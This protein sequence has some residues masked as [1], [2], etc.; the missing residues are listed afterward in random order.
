MS[1]TAA[2]RQVTASWHGSCRR[3]YPLPVPA[4]STRVTSVLAGRGG[5]SGLAPCMQAGSVVPW[6]PAS[7]TQEA[8]P[9]PAGQGGSVQPAG[10]RPSAARSAWLAT[11]SSRGLL[12]DLRAEYG[13]RCGGRRVRN[14]AGSLGSGESA[15]C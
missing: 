2:S 8:S 14:T 13:P 1:Y 6:R 10:S 7:G 5:A 3:R 15:A 9:L 4:R 12:R 11:L